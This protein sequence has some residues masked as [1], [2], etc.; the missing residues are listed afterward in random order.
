MC[1]KNQLMGCNLIAFGLGMLVGFGLESGFWCWVLG[2][3]LIAF[4]FAALQKK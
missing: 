4:G 2:V 3:G 1:R